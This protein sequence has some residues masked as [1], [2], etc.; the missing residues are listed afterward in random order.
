YWPK[1]RAG[2]SVETIYWL[3]N[4]TGESSL[5]ELAKRIHEN[6]HNWSSGV[7]DWHNVNLAQGFRE[8]GVYYQQARDSKFLHAVENNYDTVMH[9]YGQ[10][11]GGGFAGDENCRPGFGDPRQGCETCGIV[12]CMH[13]F[14]MLTKISG[15]PIWADR[16]EDIA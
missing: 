7:S 6:M 11:P 14:D 5:L 3:F 13:S 4:R 15:D 10:C 2:D 8:P 9:L 12:E 16:C 1:V